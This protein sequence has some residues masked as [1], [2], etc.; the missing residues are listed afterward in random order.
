MRAGATFF[1]TIEELRADILAGVER[2]LKGE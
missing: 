2:R 1:M